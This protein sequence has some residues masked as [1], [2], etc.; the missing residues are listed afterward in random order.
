MIHSRLLKKTHASLRS[1]ASLHVLIEY[2]S[3]RRSLTRLALRSFEQPANTV[4]QTLQD[5]IR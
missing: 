4:F 3:A 1:I 5:A 2:A